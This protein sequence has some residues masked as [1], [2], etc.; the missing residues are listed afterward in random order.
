MNLFASLR[1]KYGTKCAQDLRRLERLHNKRAR[2][3]NHQRFTLRCRDE[4][5]IPSSLKIKSPIPTANA[6]RIVKKARK[7]LVKERI[8]CTV[9]AIHN[10]DVQ[11]EEARREFK[12]HFPL[13]KEEEKFL[14]E[15]LQRVQEKEFL[16]TKRRHISKLNRLTATHRE[17]LHNNQNKTNKKWVCNLSQRHLTD[18]EQSVLARGLNFA[19]TPQTIPYEEFILATELA[20]HKIQ[21]I[22][23][24]AELRSEVAGILKSAKPTHNNTTKQEWQAI[25]AITKDPSIQVLPADKG[26]CTVLMDTNQYRSQMTTMLTDKTT[27]EIL[28]RDPTED[29]KKQLKA[30]LKPLVDQEKITKD[31]YNFIVPT[32]SVV[33]RM[34]GTPKIHKKGTPLRP[35]VDSIGSVTYKLSKELVEIIK[36]LL[37]QTE[38]HCKNSK[39]LARELSNVTVESDEIF[40]SH[41]VVSLFTKTPVDV[42]LN[43]VQERL[44]QDKTL[45]K[46]TKLTVED[47]IQLL[48]FVAKSTYFQFK[49]TFYRQKEGFA[50]GDPL[51]AIMSGFF[52]EDLEKKAIATAPEDCRLS[53]WKRYVDDILEKVKAGHTQKLTEH[54]NSIDKTGNI[55]FTH[56]EE[57]Q[58]NIAFLDMKI[59]HGEDGSIKIKVYRKPTHTDQYLLWSSEHPTAH[60]L[61]VVRTL[62]YRASIITDTQD[63]EEEEKHIKQAL[64]ACQ[65]PAWAINKGQ[66]EAQGNKKE[67]TRKKKGSKSENL[68][69]VILPYVRGVTER[70]QRAM[71]KHRISTPVKPHVKMRQLLVHP[72]DQ[73]PPEKKCDVIYEIP[74]QSCNKTYIGE[75]GR[76]FSTRK[77]EHQ[78][79]C[80]K[81]T[82]GPLTRASKHKATQENLKSAISDHC[83]RENHLMDWDKAKVIHRESNRFQ[84]WIREA[85]EIRKRAPKTVNRDEGAYQL[86]HAWDAVLRKR[87]PPYNRPPDGGGRPAPPRAFRGRASSL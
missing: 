21:N 4:G 69:M 44:R 79:E 60:K 76:Q 35:I 14:D 67:D 17:E 19:I 24:K 80:E 75:T 5:I 72:K 18:T 41:D 74:C 46:R 29:K 55:K 32:A 7:D 57:E 1:E 15:H 85:I 10:I 38:Q 78:K 36:P 31:N 84:R 56:E 39:Q 83:K 47:I 52:M 11:I 28:K 3:R 73:I 59:H 65:Y 53:L 2:F 64:K 62:F 37:G 8:R 9:N 50:M 86:A 6:E 82:A 33:P 20:C 68:G 45:H 25:Q 34:Y 42:T 48:T 81:E 58:G 61:S 26:R 51:S 12:Q 30:L 16:S 40:I 66:R 71:R 70:V 54:L 27:Y 87:P 77:K 13:E 43:I 49:G 23:D 22:G 63:R